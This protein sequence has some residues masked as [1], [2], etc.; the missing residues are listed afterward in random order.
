MLNC[1]K[2]AKISTITNA[3]DID[4]IENGDQKKE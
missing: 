3:S 1:P 4:N 2:K